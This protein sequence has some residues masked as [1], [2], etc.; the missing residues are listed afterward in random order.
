MAAMAEVFS[1][2]LPA[3]ARG[4]ALGDELAAPRRFPIG[5]V[6]IIGD[7]LR[8]AFRQ[9]EGVTHSVASDPTITF[10]AG[11]TIGPEFTKATSALGTGFGDV[12]RI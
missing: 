10:V 9:N 8:Q 4:A 11:V 3:A 5:T 2:P 1:R 6:E 12:P 7:R